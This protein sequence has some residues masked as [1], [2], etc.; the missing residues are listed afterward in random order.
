MG[1]A[2]KPETDKKLK[3]LSPNPTHSEAQDIITEYVAELREMIKKLRRRL[4]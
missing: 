4:N 3:P 2:D 1:G